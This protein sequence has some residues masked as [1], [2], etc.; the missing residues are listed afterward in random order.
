MHELGHG[1]TA[2]I[3]EAIRLYS[4]AAAAGHL[5]AAQCVQKLQNEYH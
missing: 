1:V 2:D 3:T 4:R 5:R